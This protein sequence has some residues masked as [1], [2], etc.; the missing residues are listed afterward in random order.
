M[1][2]IPFLKNFIGLKFIGILSVVLFFAACSNEEESQSERVVMHPIEKNIPHYDS[3]H[4]VVDRSDRVFENLNNFTDLEGLTAFLTDT[5]SFQ[6][7]PLDVQISDG[8]YLKMVS[9]GEDRL[10][11]L[12]TDNNFLTEYNLKSNSAVRLAQRGRGPGDIFFSRE[13]IKKGTDIFVVMEDGRI[14]QFDCTQSPCEDKETKRLE[15]KSPKSLAMTGNGMAVM[16]IPANLGGNPEAG[17]NGEN[18]AVT[19]FDR[20]Q[21]QVATFGETYDTGGHWMLMEPLVGKGY[22]RYHPEEEV[23][24]LAYRRF[25]FLYVYNSE[26]ELQQTYKISP[27][28]IGKQ[29]YEPETGKRTIVREDHDAINDIDILESG[30]VLVKI[31]KSTDQRASGGRWI[32]DEEISYYVIDLANRESFYVGSRQLENSAGLHFTSGKLFKS[33]EGDLYQLKRIVE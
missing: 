30:G 25:P 18:K 4:I 17:E 23:F 31:K 20:S 16:S 10:V 28:T 33:I 29:A 15:Q 11:M 24:I 13:L 12:D 9:V 21:N 5:G 22:I 2:K 8:F 32:W 7:V 27:F 3:D 14:T 19:V 26:Y 6:Q 1:V